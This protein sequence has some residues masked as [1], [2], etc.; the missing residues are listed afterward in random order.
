MAVA[1]GIGIKG[2]SLK[3]LLPLPKQCNDAVAGDR[4][5][6]LALRRRDVRLLPEFPVAGGDG[7]EAFRAREIG[8][9]R[10]RGRLRVGTLLDKDDGEEF[11]SPML[12]SDRRSTY[13]LA[14]TPLL[15]ST[16]AAT[17]IAPHAGGLD[18]KSFATAK[19]PK[20]PWTKYA[21]SVKQDFQAKS[22][23]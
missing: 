4:E 3:S 16:V 13:A 21:R 8:G 6:E 18:C 12:A 14:V 2:V 10:D 15:S 5:T 1:A 17:A 23:R 19:K 22:M 11:F 20:S 7:V 9:H